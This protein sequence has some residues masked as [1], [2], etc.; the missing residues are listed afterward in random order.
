M[1]FLSIDAAKTYSNFERHT[2]IV[3]MD[4]IRICSLIYHYGDKTWFRVIGL[5]LFRWGLGLRENELSTGFFKS[6]RLVCN[7][8]I[9]ILFIH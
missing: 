3:K 1:Y 4:N 6:L 5:L 9:E 2:L 7:V 8:N